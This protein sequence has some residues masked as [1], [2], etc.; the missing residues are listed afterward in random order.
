MFWSSSVCTIA[1]GENRRGWRGGKLAAC[2]DPR[3]LVVR[4]SEFHALRASIVKRS[5][6]AVENDAY[7]DIEVG[8]GN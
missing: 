2:I 3:A 4:A 1:S 8:K 7:D 6:T 5:D